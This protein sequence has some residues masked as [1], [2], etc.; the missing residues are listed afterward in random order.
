MD[1]PVIFKNGKE[2]K[3]PFAIAS[4][5]N[6]QSNAD[7]TLHDNEYQWLI[8]RAKGGYGIINT[9]CVHVQANGKGWEGELGNFDD[10]HAEGFR[11]LADGV[12]KEN[13]LLIVQIFHGGMRADDKLIQGT[14][15]SCV[16]TE[17]QHRAGTRSVQALTEAEIEE[18]IDDF[19]KGAKRVEEAGGDGIEV[20]AAHGYILTQFLCPD[21]NTRT[22]QWG[23]SSLENRARITRQVVQRIRQATSEDFIVGVRL[24]PEPGYE[25]AGWNMDPD[26]NV[27]VA[28]WL[29]E[30]GVDFVSVSLFGHS[31]SHITPKHKDK[32]G[33]KPLVQVFREALPKEVIVMSCGGVASGEDVQTLLDMGIDVAVTGKTAISTPD[34]PKKVQADPNFKVSVYPPYTKEFLASV[35]VSPPFVGFLA[36]IGMVAKDDT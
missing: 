11:K 1:Q 14:A 36:S 28:K 27:Q 33:A 21:L 4:L 15:R 22:D 18:L 10:K 7:G 32:V 26:E 29:V 13:A 6:C 31:P 19:V 5:T 2:S 8:E 9:C 34:F 16:D 20:H 17:Y 24:S 3:N 30:D 12:H 35:K 23:G 25:K